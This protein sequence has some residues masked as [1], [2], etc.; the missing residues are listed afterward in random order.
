MKDVL[1]VQGDPKAVSRVL[2]SSFLNRVFPEFTEVNKMY[3]ENR[4]VIYKK[5]TPERALV[6][7]QLIKKASFKKRVISEVASYNYVS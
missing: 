5:V 7:R 1:K 3:R 2:I 6:S 4:P